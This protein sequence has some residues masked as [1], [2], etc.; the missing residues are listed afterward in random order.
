MQLFHWLAAISGWG[1]RGTVNALNSQKAPK[2]LF[3][4]SKRCTKNMPQW[5]SA[6]RLAHVCGGVP[7]CSDEV[8][9]QGRSQQRIRLLPWAHALHQLAQGAEQRLIIQSTIIITTIIVVPQFL[10]RSQVPLQKS[11]MYRLPESKPSLNCQ[12]R[13][14]QLAGKM[15]IPRRAT[16]TK[17]VHNT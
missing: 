10:P 7:E 8:G 4:R 15:L 11:C 9:Q 12:K 3:D 6:H 17:R 14:R 13:P 16:W 2:G 1:G 5:Q